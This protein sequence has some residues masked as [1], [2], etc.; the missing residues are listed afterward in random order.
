MGKGLF[1]FL[2][3]MALWLATSVSGCATS[4]DLAT[5]KREVLESY[6][7]Q[8]ESLESHRA[9]TKIQFDAMKSDITKVSQDL[10]ADCDIKIDGVRSALAKSSQDLNGLREKVTDLDTKSNNL[11]QER[12]KVHAALQSATRRILFLFKKEE[13]EL[14]DRIRFLQEVIKEYGAEEAGK[15]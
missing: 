5:L 15:K 8:T 1:T 9:D 4:G 13:S 7:D 11:V 6:V 10:K 14:K 3:L 12:E 2:L